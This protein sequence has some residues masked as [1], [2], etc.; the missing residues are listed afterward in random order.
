VDMNEIMTTARKAMTVRRVFGDAYEKDGVT[1]IPAAIVVGGVGGGGGQS[2]EG[3]SGEGGGFGV[4]ASPA[5]AFSIR[6]G[7]VRWHPSINVNLVIA[8]AAAVAV[9]YLVTRSRT[10]RAA[11]ARRRW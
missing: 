3:E 9:T 1:V 8:A 7:R 2:G 6:D 4:R 10:A 5:G 11:A